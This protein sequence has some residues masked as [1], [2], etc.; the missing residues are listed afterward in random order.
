VPRP[1]PDVLD[2]IVKAY[3]IRGLVDGELDQSVARAL[4]VAAA[5]VLV[6]DDQA[7]V[8]GR[9]MRPSSPM[10]VDAFVDGVTS[11]GVDVIDVGLASTDLVTYAS[12]ELGLPSAMFTASHNPPTYNGIK[13]SRAGAVPVSITSG[14]AELRDVAAGVLARR[15]G[16]DA[17]T[18]A[19]APTETGDTEGSGA[20]TEMG[21]PA[22]MSDTDGEPVRGTRTELDLL[23]RFAA[24]VRSFVDVGALTEVSVAVDA[25]NG[26]A[27]HVWPA[28]V[29]GTPIVTEELYF[30]LDGTFPN[31]PA[32]PL[33]P[34]NLRD[35]QA[36]VRAGG[37]ALGLAFDGDADRVF[38]VDEMGR[39]VPSS[40]VGAV[41][42]DRLLRRDP[43]ATV[44]Y[45]L[46][47]SRTVPETINAAGGVAVRTRVGHSFIKERMAETGAIYA[48][49]HSG[50]HYFRDN[51]RADSGVITALVLLEA[52][53]DAGAP[54][55]EVVAPYDKYAAS[56]EHDVE[57]A[58]TH[59]ALDHVREDFAGRGSVD[60]ED[61]L[62]IDTEEG[63]FSL[64]P[65]NTE[66]VLRLNVE[67][68]D[69]AAVAQLLAE[70][71]AAA[72]RA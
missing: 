65:S 63:W 15:P 39:I 29:A 31:H 35:L 8:V 22:E 40:L 12:G 18:P 28:V 56:G 9:D 59:A 72:R 13:L 49:E 1:S 61:G 30:E 32:N 44:L 4:G 58:D 67:A 33:D 71:T 48:V 54:L 45:N 20:P 60:E 69:A 57:V 3:D 14:L 5:T 66:P 37:H 16:A 17:N 64:R 11:Q 51:H 42:A 41:V 27:G 43:G 50:H 46:V 25:G 70:V 10:L 52:V 21:A 34:A 68:D 6:E 24:H 23:E 53:A 55:S 7:M 47:C 2:R 36:A 38:A 26:M 19:G 62:L